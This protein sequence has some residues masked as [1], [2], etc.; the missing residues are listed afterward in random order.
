[1][2]SNKYKKMLKW[3]FIILLALI[4]SSI[5][6][7]CKDKDWR[8]DLDELNKQA[9]MKL[10]SDKN[11]LLSLKKDKYKINNSFEN[12]DKAVQQYLIELE[13]NQTS[14]EHAYVFSKKELKEILYPNA[15]GLGTSLDKTP[16]DDYEKLIWERR[17]L[18]EARILQK[19]P[20][21]F[22]VGKIFWK[23]EIRQIG[24]LKGHKPESIEI[25]YKENKYFINEIKQV[26]EHNGQFKVAIV[27]P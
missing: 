3:K 20:S 16:L 21:G 1:M 19:L 23:D 14:D 26:I 7:S 18:G 27:S 17:K 24:V 25:I 10:K 11:L 6:I 4:F 9:E 15:L 5:L 8:E 12:R 2:V 13:K 22:K